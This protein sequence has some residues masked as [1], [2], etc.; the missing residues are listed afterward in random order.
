MNKQLMAA[1]AVA[2]GLAA[3][4]AVA[5]AGAGMG[6]ATARSARGGAVSVQGLLPTESASYRYYPSAE[7]YF[8]PA[9]STY[10]YRQNN[11]WFSGAGVPAG[12]TLGKY[13]TVRMTGT[14]TA[15]PQ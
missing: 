13:R 9:T 3:G 15:A 10:Y 4:A 14:A 7:V 1:L 11:R 12:V 2:G 8:S 6:A 5:Q